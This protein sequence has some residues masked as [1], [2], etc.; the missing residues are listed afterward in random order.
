MSLDHAAHQVLPRYPSLE[1]CDL[2]PLGNHGGFSGARLWHLRLRYGPLLCLRAWPTGTDVLRLEAIHH[3]M[4]VAAN[5]GLAFVPRVHFTWNV[6][7]YAEQAGRLWDVTT[8]L[9]GRADFHQHPSRVRLEAA[10]TALAQLHLAWGTRP[11]WS[12]HCP[13]VQRRL[14][15]LADWND[16]VRGGWRPL[17]QSVPGD[18]V[19]PWAEL[20]WPLLERHLPAVERLLAPWQS[21]RTLIQPCLC[22]PWHDH[23]LF[24]GDTVS[25]IV[26]YGSYKQDHVAVDLARLLG[27]LIGDDAE[28]RELG[29]DAYQ[30]VRRLTAED[31]QLVRVL[32]HTGTVIGVANWLRW[33]FHDDRVFEDRAAVAA[34]LAALVMRLGRWSEP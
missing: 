27:S 20:A 31:R 21:R 22:D 15:H 26:D 1:G 32:D 9:P 23:I 13:A 25:G 3:Q 18:P 7:S 12:K 29:L 6:H 10:C 30:R 33:L 5:A 4:L 19:R 34:R 17:A 16:L 14:A 11:L 8:W 24:E 28:M 2:L